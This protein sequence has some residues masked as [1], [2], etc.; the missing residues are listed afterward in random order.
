MI[1]IHSHLLPN[2]DDG[3]T[4]FEESVHIIKKMQDLGYKKIIITPHYIKGTKY[5]TN[6]KDKFALFLK[7]NGLLKENN[8]DMQ[9]Y[10]GNEIFLDESILELL[11]TG[12]ACTLNGSRY[13]C[14]ELPRNDWINNLDDIIFKLKSKNIIPI[15]AHPERY[16]MIKQD[17]TLLED[18]KNRGVL[19]QVNFESINGKYGK[20]AKKLVKYI[21]KNN[22]ASFIGG[23][24]H[25]EN[26]L[27]FKEYKKTK[28]KL[29][30]IISEEKLMELMEINPEKVI[31]NQDI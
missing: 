13:V 6:N 12:E 10:L 24:I 23:D 1:E 21:L 15:I 11:K 3:S 16:I 22:L 18:L 20:D 9:I 29:L 27:F 25:H 2:I 8:I 17:Y 30:K 26:S 5:N 31:C 7:L 4:S 19:F 14:V 28:K